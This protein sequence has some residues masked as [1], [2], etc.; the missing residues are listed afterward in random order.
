MLGFSDGTKDGGY[1]TANWGIYKAK[2]ALTAVS[3]EFNIKLTFFDG[4]GGPAARGGGKTHNFYTSHGRS[5]ENTSLH[6]IKA[7]LLELNH[8]GIS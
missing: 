6:L 4:R 3:E 8:Y 5:I 1:F 2:E 7:G